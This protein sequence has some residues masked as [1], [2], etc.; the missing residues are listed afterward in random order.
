MG[1]GLRS[2]NQWTDERTK[3][4]NERGV[5]MFRARLAARGGQKRRMERRTGISQRSMSSNIRHEKRGTLTLLAILLA[6]NDLQ[7]AFE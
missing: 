5:C 4:I 7:D 3:K 1:N 6:V 2:Q